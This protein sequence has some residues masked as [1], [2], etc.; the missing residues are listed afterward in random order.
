MTLATII[1]NEA[2]ARQMHQHPWKQTPTAVKANMDFIA[3]VQTS[4]HF[5]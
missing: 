2:Q 4:Y 1:A 5:E 3:R